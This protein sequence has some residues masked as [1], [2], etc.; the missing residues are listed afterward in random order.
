MKSRSAKEELSKSFTVLYRADY[1]IEQ[2]GI[3]LLG[4]MRRLPIRFARQL[5]Q[6]LAGFNTQ[7]G[8]WDQEET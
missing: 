2:A 7:T 6:E 8:G 5:K 3:L 1:V 4:R